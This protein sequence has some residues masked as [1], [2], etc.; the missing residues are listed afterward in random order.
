MK[1]LFPAFFLLLAEIALL[2]AVVWANQFDVGKKAYDEQHYVEAEAIWLPLA[3]NGDVHAQFQLA[4]LYDEGLVKVD[5]P[6]VEA[7]KWYERAALQGHPVAGY[8]LGNAYK[9][10]RGTLQ[11]DKLANYWWQ[12]ASDANIGSAQFNLALQFHQGLG[13]ERDPEQTIL[14]INRAALNGHDKARE[15]LN[16]NQ[17]PTVDVDL[18]SQPENP[19]G[20]DPSGGGQPRPETGQSDNDWLMARNPGHFCLQLGVLA[21]QENIQGFKDNFGLADRIRV[22]ILIRGEQTFHYIL[23]GDYA[24]RQEAVSALDTLP[25]AVRQL[26]PWARRFGELQAMV[27]P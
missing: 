21:R 4:T 13:V 17:V 2:P 14:L 12:K 20:D 16:T 27:R 24:S 26:Q 3:R 8:N 10:G 5:D 1:V 7:F 9:H 19:P 22:A 11:S 23:I 25:S 18:S 6:Q 15:L